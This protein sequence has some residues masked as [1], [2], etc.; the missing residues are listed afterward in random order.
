MLKEQRNVK[1]KIREKVK[2]MNGRDE[3]FNCGI[4]R[5]RKKNQINST[6]RDL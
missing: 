3:K 1:V 5:K 2:S 6:E 4:K